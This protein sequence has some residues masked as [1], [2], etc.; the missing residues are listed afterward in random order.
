MGCPGAGTNVPQQVALSGA[1][2]G[3]GLGAQAV[4]RVPVGGG[5][6]CPS[7]SNSSILF[8]HTSFLDV[9]RWSQPREAALGPAPA[10]PVGVFPGDWQASVCS[11][12][13][14]AQWPRVW[15]VIEPH[16]QS[17]QTM[18]T[19]ESFWKAHRVG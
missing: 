13:G 4:P 7:A 19:K 18:V 15:E 1:L 12:W 11:R 17:L 16:S 10:P 3:T 2:P 5:G 14:S 6:L 9:P 8:L